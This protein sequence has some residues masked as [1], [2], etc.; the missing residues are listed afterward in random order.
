M[1]EKSLYLL[2]LR[3]IFSVPLRFNIRHALKYFL[4][5]WLKFCSLRASPNDMFRSGN[6][7]YKIFKERFCVVGEDNL[8]F[9][10]HEKLKN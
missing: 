3:K 2:D 1:K 4:A 6:K 10:A 9:Y 5:V 7:M 8:N